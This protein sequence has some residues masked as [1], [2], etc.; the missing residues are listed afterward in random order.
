M[1]ETAVDA[2]APD[3][4]GD[5]ERAGGR[6]VARCEGVPDLREQASV[7][8]DSCPAAAVADC[9]H[10]EAVLEGERPSQPV[11]GA[12]PADDG[13]VRCRGPDECLN[14]QAARPRQAARRIGDLDVAA[15]LRALRASVVGPV[16]RGVDLVLSDSG[17]V[18]MGVAVH[19]SDELGVEP[20]PLVAA[21]IDALR[22]AGRDAGAIAIAPDEEP[23]HVRGRPARAP[24]GG[25]GTPDGGPRA[26][27]RTDRRPAVP[28]ARRAP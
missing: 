17:A 14:R 13:P 5:E 18:R 12:S 8:D 3:P 11:G 20:A 4:L 6:V 24:R 25:G 19:Q 28:A 27:R 2:I 26:R 7:A 15:D 1:P 23:R 22:L 21:H 10:R 16:H 9:E